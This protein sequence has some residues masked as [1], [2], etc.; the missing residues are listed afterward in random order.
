M[1][2]VLTTMVAAVLI[3]V[4]FPASASADYPNPG[5][6][7]GDVNVHDPAMIKAANGTYFL[8]STGN[9]IDIRTSTDR[10]AFRRIGSAFP[11]GAS[12]AHP[13]TNGSNHLWA[14]D[15]SFR[16]GQFYLYYSAS[17]FG[18]RNSAI[19][20]A[21]STTAMPGS[22]TN[23]GIVVQTSNNSDHNAIDPNLV[24]DASG[25]WWLN[26]GSFWTG[27][28]LVRINPG[29]GKPSDGTRYNLAQRPAN[30]DGAV[31]APYIVYREGY[32][33]LFVSFDFCCRGTASTYRVMVGR[34]T[35]VT[36][37][38]VDRAGVAMTNG[39]GTEVLA[40][41]GTIYGPGHPAAMVDTDG[42]LL[43]YHYYPSGASRLGINRIGWSGGWPAVF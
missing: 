42:W 33:Y 36:G 10:V 15:I 37:P 11:N 32:Y 6:V 24:V 18:S 7:T 30:V 40:T 20:L 22:W 39:G 9:G 26:Y 29:T 21:T 5:V 27:I 31:E 3:L 4:G 28:K 1:R 16:N 23:Q 2:R 12:W 25:A 13:F 17:T 8:F 43:I 38:Y 14:P 35:S 19:F 41:H 34:S